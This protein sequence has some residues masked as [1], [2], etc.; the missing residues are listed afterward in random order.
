MYVFIRLLALNAK[1]AICNGGKNTGKS[2][3]T[4]HKN[5]KVHVSKQID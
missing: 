4:V 2:I 3:I 1:I 5:E